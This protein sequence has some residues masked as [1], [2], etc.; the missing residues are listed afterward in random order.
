MNT[1]EIEA[2]IREAYAGLVGSAG[3]VPL[4]DLRAALPGLARDVVD[5]AMTDMQARQEA[6]LI[7]EENQKTLTPADR[8][9]AIYFGGQA[10]HLIV[11]EKP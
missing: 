4:R 8:D 2:Q 7:P 1:T 6:L 11:I 5:Q 3:W 9:A 10:R